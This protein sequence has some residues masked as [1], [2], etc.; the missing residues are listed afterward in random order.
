MAFVHMCFIIMG[1]M[2]SGPK[3]LDGFMLYL[4]LLW[5]SNALSSSDDILSEEALCG[6]DVDHEE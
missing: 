6:M 5:I 2:F 1:A 4:H 3:F